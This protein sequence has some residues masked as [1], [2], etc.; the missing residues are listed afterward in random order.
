VTAGDPAAFVGALQYASAFDEVMELGMTV[1]P[2]IEGDVIV[3]KGT[4][5]DP[6]LVP[7]DEV[8]LTSSGKLSKKEMASSKYWTLFQDHACACAIRLAR[9]TLAVLPLDRVIVTIERIQLDTSTGHHGP[10]A[11][12]SVHFDRIKLS[13]LNVDKIDPSDSMKNFPHRMKFKKTSGFEAIEPITP[14]ENW[15]ST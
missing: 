1:Q 2:R 14:D 3:I 13:S 7:T 6:E 11:I 12:L 15:V 4:I 8:K 9:E 5:T 10:V